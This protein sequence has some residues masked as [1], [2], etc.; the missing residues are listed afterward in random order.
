[1]KVRAQKANSAVP[2]RPPTLVALFSAVLAVCA[3]GGCAALSEGG[4]SA[5]A[6]RYRVAARQGYE[7]G[8]GFQLYRI[9]PQEFPN[10]S[11]VAAFR[12]ADP[13]SDGG[14]QLRDEVLIDVTIAQAV[15]D[16]GVPDAIALMSASAGQSHWCAIFYAKPP[17]T[18]VFERTTMS[19]QWVSLAELYESR[20]TV[21]MDA[22][23]RSVQR[24]AFGVGP[25]PPPWPVTLTG[26]SRDA[27]WVSTP[28]EPPAQVDGS[29]YADV[30]ASLEAGLPRSASSQ[31]Q[32]RAKAALQRLAQTAAAAGL[33]W[34]VAV[35]GGQGPMGFGVPNGSLFVSDGLVEKLNDDE[36]AGL[37]AHLMGHERYQHARACARSRNLFAATMLVGGAFA[38][39]GGGMGFFVIPTNSYLGLI[40]SPQ[41]GYSDDYEAQANYAAAR[42]LKDAKIAPDALFDAMAKLIGTGQGQPASYESLHHLETATATYG[43]MLDAGAVE[44]D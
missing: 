18:I 37:L 34:K 25:L 29:D 6:A 24:L 7:S 15:K 1:M 10:G 17:R 35:I 20:V 23:P 41:F 32:S 16:N 21:R 19:V 43:L 30:A 8:K 26:A 12:D 11:G 31:N 38:V 4:V 28:A 27:F 13:S 33:P 39:A 42:I 9:N 3:A 22:A 44:A 36:L 40:A 2:I 5:E 14:K